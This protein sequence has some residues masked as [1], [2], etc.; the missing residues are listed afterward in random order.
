MTRLTDDA[1]A[2]HE[3]FVQRV[4]ETGLVW[5]LKGRRRLGGL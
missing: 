3:L 4:Q 2:N 5:G 1:Q